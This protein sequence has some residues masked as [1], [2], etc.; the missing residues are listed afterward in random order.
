MWFVK[1]LIIE[2]VKKENIPFEGVCPAEVLLGRD[3]RPSGRSLLEAAKQGVSS[4]VGAIA[5]DMGFLTT[6]QLHWMVL[7]GFDPKGSKI[8]EMDDKLIVDGANGVGGEKLAG[9]KKMFNS[10]VIDVRN[11]GKEGGVL[12]EGVGADYVQKEKVVPCGFGPSDVG[13]RCASLDGDADRLVYF[14]VLPK[15][16]N[17]DLIDGDK[18]LQL[19]QWGI[20]DYLKK[21]GLEVLFTPTGVKYLHEKAAEF[22]IGIY[23]E[24]NGHGTILFSEEFLCWLELEIMNFLPCLKVIADMISSLGRIDIIVKYES[25]GIIWF[26]SGS[27]QKKAALRLLQSAS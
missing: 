14:L 25:S 19:M 8:N 9:L 23:F 26:I 12:N 11:S 5:L 10:L 20:T 15:D 24:A 17:I 13:L 3:T 16:N 18:I 6:P 4:I 22:D 21:Q 2:F 7:D 1:Q 27:E